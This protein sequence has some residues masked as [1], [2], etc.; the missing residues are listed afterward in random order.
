MRSVANIRTGGRTPISGVL[1]S[2]ILLAVLL[3]LG[4]LGEKIPLAVLG[5]I[6]FKVDID[7]IDWRF[8]RHILQAPASMSSS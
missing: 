5:R 7:I 2:I 6:L 1:H 4:P 8:L 3:G